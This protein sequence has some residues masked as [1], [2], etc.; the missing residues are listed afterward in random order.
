MNSE[1]VFAE[2][3]VSPCG[4]L[5]AGGGQR[6]VIRPAEDDREESEEEERRGRGRWRDAQRRARRRRKEG[7]TRNRGEET[8]VYVREQST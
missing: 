5:T 7:Q 2:L 3:C 6:A 4:S 1:S 8:G